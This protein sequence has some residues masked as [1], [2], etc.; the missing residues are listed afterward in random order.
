MLKG[1]L[2]FFGGAAKVFTWFLTAIVIPMT[3]WFVVLREDV[4]G[5]QRDAVASR[6]YVQ[7]IENRVYSVERDIDQKHNEVLRSLGRIEGELKRIR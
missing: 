6:A 7:L 5:L 3:A 4:K 2:E 1:V